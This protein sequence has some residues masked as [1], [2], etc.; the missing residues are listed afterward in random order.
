MF[1]I[2]HKQ[3][4]LLLFT[5][6]ALSAASV[7]P[8]MAHIDFQDKTMFRVPLATIVWLFLCC[9]YLFGYSIY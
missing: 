4:G 1:N 2:K 8:P 7:L 5:A 9:F 3:Y 6:I